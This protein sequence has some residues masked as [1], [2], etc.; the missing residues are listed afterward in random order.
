MTDRSRA[1]LLALDGFPL[2]AF[3]QAVTPNLWRLAEEGGFSPF[4]GRS[5]LPSTTYPAFASLLTGMNQQRTGIRTTARRPGAVPG[6]AGRA[7]CLVPT[8]I[9]AARDAG[10]NTAVAMGDHKLQRVLSLHEIDRAWPPAE[11]VPGGTE[12]DAHGYPTNAAVRPHALQAAADPDV[13]LMFVHLN[14]T[15]TLGHDLGPDA[16]AT[17]DCVRAADALVGELR[18]VLEPDWGRTV[19]AVVSDHDMIRRL[20]LPPIDPTD[21]RE[22]AGLV[23]DWIADGA[24]GPGYISPPAW[25]LTWR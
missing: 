24:A 3:Q 18:Q 13:D 15:D 19:L 11:V 5:G 4:G 17:L 12:V 23:D 6:W 8:V 1:V 20:P 7:R 16:G 9:H 14:E 10:L 25:T 22:C 2:Q 21:S